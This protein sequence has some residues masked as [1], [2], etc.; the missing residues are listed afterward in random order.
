MDIDFVGI[1][2]R[3]R[4]SVEEIGR[5]RAKVRSALRSSNIRPLS[6]DEQL[7][8]FLK[9]RPEDIQKLVHKH[10]ADS[11]KEYISRMLELM[12]SKNASGSSF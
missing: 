11:V 5:R 4:K 2:E 7:E 10:G 6:P 9:S 3:V 1:Q 12:E 8:R